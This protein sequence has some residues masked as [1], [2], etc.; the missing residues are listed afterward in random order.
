[1]KEFNMEAKSPTP[2]TTSD[3]D[4]F[5]GEF[6]QT[7]SELISIFLKLLQRKKN[8]SK[9]ILEGQHYSDMKIR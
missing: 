4:G 9:L 3:L 2:H 5:T 8:I 6:Y 1:M 7:Y